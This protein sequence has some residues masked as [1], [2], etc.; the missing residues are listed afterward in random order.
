[1][2]VS[3]YLEYWVIVLSVGVVVVGILGV[4]GCWCLFIFNIS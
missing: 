2:E 4:F 3:L 1:M